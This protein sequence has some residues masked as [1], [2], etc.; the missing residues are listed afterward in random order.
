L[1]VTIILFEGGLALRLH[2]L[3]MQ[4][5]SL[6]LLLSAGAAFS[7]VIGALAARF[8]L[9]M[10]WS[11]AA[12]YG[13]IV[14]VTGPTVVTPL[15][16]RLAVDRRVRDLLIAEGVLIDPIGAVIAIVL[17][18]YFLGEAGAWSA[19]LLVLARLSVGAVIGG[20]AAVFLSFALRRGLVPEHLRNPTVLAS[21]LFAATFSSRI[22]S[23]AGLMCAVMQGVILANAGLYGTGRMRQFKEELTVLLLSFIFV[24]LA[25][26]LPVAAVRALGWQGLAVV[27][28]LLWV[29]RPLSVAVSTWGTDLR[30]G[31]KVFLSWICPRGIVAASVASLFGIL[32]EEKGIPG[33]ERL[34]ALVFLTVAVSVALQGLSASLVAKATGVNLPSLRGAI[35]VGGDR[36][37]RLI[38]RILHEQGRQVVI[39][40]NNPDHCAAAR[41]AGLAVYQGDALSPETLE[42]AGVRFVDTVLAMTRNLELN[43]LVAR[44]VQENFR[45][46]RVFALGA[47][48]SPGAERP[49]AGSLPH[50]DQINLALLRGEARLRRYRVPQAIASTRC[51][52]LP[53]AESEAALVIERSGHALVAKGSESLAEGDLLV[54]LQLDPTPSPLE[55]MLELVDDRPAQ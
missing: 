5:R 26:D 50:P 21:V 33:G 40:D 45:V 52:A 10:S 41:A 9:G 14:I 4:Q 35:I 18:E 15:L 31:E 1:A 42:A 46:E 7:L 27:G 54:C 19:G 43:D 24:A 16:A 20:A 12:L 44:L 11:L 22:S 55:T 32:L 36:F 37:G 51:A 38:G 2:D 3:R 28:A 8:F 49:F 23:E 6:L 53:F 48:S 25:A 34:E 30:L 47:G 39:V 13:A 17:A 29:A